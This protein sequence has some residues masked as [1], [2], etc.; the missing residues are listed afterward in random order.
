[1]RSR[2][3][4]AQRAAGGETADKD[5]RVFGM[6]LH[7]DPVPQDGAPGEWRGRID[8]KNADALLLLPEGG[9]ERVDQGALSRPGSAGNADDMGAAGVGK[10]PLDGAP[11]LGDLILQ[12]P[13]QAGSGSDVPG[14]DLLQ[15]IPFLG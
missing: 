8:G 2:G 15:L 5:A 10:N 7:P 9:N 11:R 13:D 4:A 1:M 6:A 3:E 14:A 12:V